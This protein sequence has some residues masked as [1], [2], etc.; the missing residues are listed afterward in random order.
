MSAIFRMAWRFE[1][2]QK[3]KLQGNL[4]SYFRWPA[5]LGLLL[6][7][8]DITLLVYDVK[9]GLVG[10]LYL[11]LYMGI[12][13][14]IYWSSGRKLNEE[15][16]GFAMKYDKVLFDVY[17]QLSVPFA[18]LSQDG[19]MLWGNTACLRL[20]VNKK[21]AK[22]NISNVFPE[23]TSE[24]LP[25]EGEDSVI[26]IKTGD[27][28]YRVHM[29]RVIA[30]NVSVGHENNDVEGNETFGRLFKGSSLIV[31][32]LYDETEIVRLEK[33]REDENL[34]VGLL[35]IDNYDELLDSI[36]EERQSLIPALIERKINKYMQG[37]DAIL[38][39]LE[40]DK[41]IFVFKQKYLSKLQEERFSI[42]EEIRDINV[43][44]D[45]TSTISIGIGVGNDAF[46]ERH[47]YARA[48]IDLALG[49][50]GDQAVV[51]GSNGDMFYGGK[52]D[53]KER[54]TR[55]KARVKAHA[56]RGLI[57]SNE[58]VVV[59]GHSIGDAD[60]FGA[61]VG[62]YRIAKTLN[63][64]AY[65]V[66]DGLNS[67]VK[68]IR[69]T[70]YSKDYENDMMITGDEAKELVDD[71]TVLVVVDVNRGSYTE[72]PDLLEQTQNIVVID[73]HRQAGDAITQAVLFYMEPYASSACEMVAEI[74]QYIGSGLRLRPAEAEALFAGIMIDT[75]HFT[76]KTGVRTFEA[77]A[78]LRR[79]GAD[80][81]RVHKIFR[82]SMEEYKVRAGAI[83]GTE[84]YHGVY[85]IAESRSDGIEAPTV[86]ASKVAN[87]LLD[88]NDVRASF[89][90]TNYNGKVYISA[91]SIDDRNVQVMMERLGGGGH[92]NMAGAQLSDVTAA[93]AKTIIKQQIDEM[94]ADGE[95]S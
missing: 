62:I 74:S 57:E 68:P 70:F 50:G 49:R 25:N 67:S 94:I 19:Q 41:Y 15:L 84:L 20:I 59:M 73:H 37:I 39:K 52:S 79:N 87:S 54:N 60:S 91:R 4:G 8:M 81:M 82:E 80:T 34:L 5:F 66:V 22:K 48:A 36:D 13:F 69:E 17:E 83:Q 63:R 16:V 78:Y 75:N 32:F 58:K 65:I 71:N 61:S 35:Y 72:C 10:L 47:E 6:F 43:G 11:A 1:M 27:E 64:R 40:N 44:N 21:A 18:V 46:I 95:I 88:I 89:V 85:A 24:S 3:K 14:L 45:Q 31:M 77:M 38:K 12:S 86:F 9:A 29:R 53:Q 90:L 93:Q 2:K 23:I 56:L 92:M 26:R 51:K 33:E 55:E 42:L 7:A 76:S 28:T 30:T